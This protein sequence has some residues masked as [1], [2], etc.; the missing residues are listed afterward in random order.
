MTILPKPMRNF[1]LITADRH[2]EEYASVLPDEE[3]ILKGSS[4][5]GHPRSNPIH[6]AHHG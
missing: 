6:W 5:S 2:D 1:R 3:A 4:H